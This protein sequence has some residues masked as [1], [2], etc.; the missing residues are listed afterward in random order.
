MAR[1]QALG[2][3]KQALLDEVEKVNCLLE[4]NQDKTRQIWSMLEAHAARNIKSPRVKS[5]NLSTVHRRPYFVD[6]AGETPP[7]SAMER[8]KEDIIEKFR[9]RPPWT[10]AE[11]LRLR[12][13]LRTVAKRRLVRARVAEAKRAVASTRHAK[14]HSDAKLISDLNK[15][16]HVL[17][18][19]AECEAN[20]AS[21]V[22]WEQLSEE[23]F[24]PPKRRGYTK[25]GVAVLGRSAHECRI[26]WLAFEDPNINRGP[27]S[28]QEELALLNAV[29]ARGG[30]DWQQ[31]SR[32]LQTAVPESRR[33]P[34]ACLRQ[35][36]SKGNA[37]LLRSKWEP[38]E[39]ERLRE[40][41]GQY[42]RSN[43][44]KVAAEMPGRSL[45]QIL[46]RWDRYVRPGI[47]GRKPWTA[48]QDLRVRLGMHAYGE[49]YTL[50][51]TLVPG[52]TDIQINERW[53][54]VLR[55]GLNRSPWVAEEDTALLA[56][57]RNMFDPEKGI[58][59]EVKWK[60]VAV[61]LGG[62]RTDSQCW[63][64]WRSLVPKDVATKY[65]RDAGLR[66][67]NVS[68]RSN[69][70]PSELYRFRTIAAQATAA[71]ARHPHPSPPVPPPEPPS[72]PPRAPP[73]EQTLTA[74]SA[75]APA[76]DAPVIPLAFAPSGVPVENPAT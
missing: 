56:A 42:G 47:V 52:R 57:V 69:C 8:R 49:R 60:V 66:K 67:I 23:F 28:K 75:E 35:F 22:D 3:L 41:M 16:Q 73:P 30:R 2:K 37:S 1:L 61:Q 74:P 19:D 68:G 21:G 27:W 70:S 9:P 32:D 62:A 59:G 71:C 26:Q 46:H 76:D 53:K 43:L 25:A 40:I 63:H 10:E 65:Q 33:T 45:S 58:H 24:P 5:I 36:Q 39:D 15:L 17:E 7:T 50:I 55:P 54:N 4:Y 51:Q 14:L 48:E 34:F 29:R 18:D 44:Q 13:A 11:R 6:A 31:I 38:A 12:R 64:R 20:I 72:A